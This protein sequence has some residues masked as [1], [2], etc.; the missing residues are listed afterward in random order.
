LRIHIEKP[1]SP[2][3]IDPEGGAGDALADGD[4]ADRGR[5]E[6]DLQDP[7]DRTV[8]GEDLRGRAGQ[9]ERLDVTIVPSASRASIVQFCVSD[10]DVGDDLDGVAGGD[11]REV[12]PA[13]RVDRAA[14]GARRCP[15]A[16]RRGTRRGR[17]RRPSS[18]A[19]GLPCLTP[20]GHVSLVSSWTPP[21]KTPSSVAHCV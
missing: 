14:D 20:H 2:I 4:R 18:A 12:R 5:R 19:D 9:R 16:W 1:R 11:L 7:V 3:G 10:A 6:L 15:T 21:W 13:E 17:Q 8:A